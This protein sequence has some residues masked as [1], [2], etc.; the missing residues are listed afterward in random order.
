MAISQELENAIRGS[1]HSAAGAVELIDICNAN[2]ATDT[3]A[4]AS[5]TNLVVATGLTVGSTAVI[6]SVNATTVSA[7]SAYAPALSA[8]NAVLAIGLS[9]PTVKAS[10]MSVASNLSAANISAGTVLNAASILATNLS[11]GTQATIPNILCSSNLSVASVLATNVSVKTGLTALGAVV[12]TNGI[13]CVSGPMVLGSKH[14]SG[15]TAAVDT[16]AVLISAPVAY[17]VLTAAGNNY[18]K[19]P[20]V[21]AG[22]C[23]N[24]INAGTLTAGL[25]GRTAGVS[26]NSAT[27]VSLATANATGAALDLICDGT[28]WW[29]R[30]Q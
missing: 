28:N 9:C 4:A 2:L 11:V 7:A 1:V 17:L 26:I 6:Q 8:T 23:Q 14:V 30:A 3:Y 18:F 24:V 10:T 13:N 25:V 5:I 29:K 27:S 15:G 19:L 20:A 16:Q 21:V 22:L 12:G